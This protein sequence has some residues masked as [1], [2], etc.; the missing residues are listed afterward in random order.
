[1]RVRTNCGNPAPGAKKILKQKR[2]KTGLNV[3]SALTHNITTK[4]LSYLY[5]SIGEAGVAESGS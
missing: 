5:V 1:M 2:K 3:Q 4:E